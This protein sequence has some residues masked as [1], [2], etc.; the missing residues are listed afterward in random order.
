MAANMQHMGTPGMMPQ[1]PQQRPNAAQGQLQSYLVQ[2]LKNCPQ[3][4][5]GNTW[6]NTLSLQERLTKSL[7]LC[8]PPRYLLA[9]DTNHFPSGTQLILSQGNNVDIGR[10]AEHIANFEREM[11]QKMPSKASSSYP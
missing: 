10:V 3:P 6:H 9:N 8:V 5:N 4:L 2:A 7:H 1:H 11:Y